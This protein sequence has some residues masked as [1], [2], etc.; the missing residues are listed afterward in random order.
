MSLPLQEEIPGSHSDA[1]ALTGLVLQTALLV[2]SVVLSVGAVAALT[3]RVILR[4][5]TAAVTA[6]F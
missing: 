6:V 4:A 1:S 5:A 3:G 2:L